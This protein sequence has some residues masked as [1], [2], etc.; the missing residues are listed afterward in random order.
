MSGIKNLKE[1]S[2]IQLDEMFDNKQVGKPEIQKN[3]KEESKQNPHLDTQQ[4]MNPINKPEDSS[5]IKAPPLSS[6]QFSNQMAPQPAEKTQPAPNLKSDVSRLRPSVMF[7]NKSIPN[8][9]NP[10]Y[11]MTFMLT[12]DIYKAFNDLYAHRMLQGRK[13]DKSDMICEAIQWLIK[14]EEEQTN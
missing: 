7:S 5:F 12:E 4:L 9:K 2:K 1:K 6:I 8:Q 14:M 13:T 3:G 11:K 10:T